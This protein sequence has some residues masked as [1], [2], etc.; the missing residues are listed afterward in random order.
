M[1][2]YGFLNLYLEFYLIL[3]KGEK[4]IKSG[5]GKVNC[6]KVRKD[7]YVDTRIQNKSLRIGQGTDFAC[8]FHNL[9]LDFLE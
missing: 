1:G 5:V 3:I 6:N 4:I 9:K 8:R 2:S 7:W